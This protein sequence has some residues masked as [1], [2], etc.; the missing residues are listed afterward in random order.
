MTIAKHTKFRTKTHRTSHN[1]GTN[2]RPIKRGVVDFGTYHHATPGESEE[3][4]RR[5]EKA[6]SKL[7]RP[8]YASG[9]RL[10]IMDAGCGLG[11]LMYVAAK[12]FP[13]A[14]IVGVDLFRRGS[15]SGISMDKA[16]NN[17]QSLG[18]D[19]RTSFLKHD[20]TKPMVS[21]EQYDLV[22]SNLVFHNM[23]KKRFKA[24]EAVFDV[25]KSGGFFVVGDVFP[26]HKADMDYFR[27]RSTVVNDLNEGGSGG[28]P[29]KIMALR[30]QRKIE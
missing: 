4:R 26:H 7:L 5:A 15:I 28:W 6:F 1:P 14:H 23:G 24:Y 10:R 19:S 25:L 30:K 13:K 22:V 16:A 3:I 20:L 21:N 18:L 17:M 27:E 8:L 11:F 29:Y 2:D 12:R 9:S